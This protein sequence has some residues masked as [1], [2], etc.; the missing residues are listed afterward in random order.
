MISVVPTPSADK[1]TIW[2][3][4]TCFCGLFR[5][6]VIAVRRLW[7]EELSLRETPVRMPQIRMPR[8]R[9]ESLAGLLCQ[10]L[11]TSSFSARAMSNG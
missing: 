8:R 7:S 5:S 3:R 1:S 4:Q 10:V 11:S 9:R 6:V 2:A